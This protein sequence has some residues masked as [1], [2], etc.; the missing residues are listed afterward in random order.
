MWSSFQAARVRKG[1][2]SIGQ[3]WDPASGKVD[4][5][6]LSGVVERTWNVSAGL[7]YRPAAGLSFEGHV[8]Y[9]DISNAGHTQGADRQH[10]TSSINL[11]ARW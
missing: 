8:G 9:S 7:T 10:V 4:N 2:G 6:P 11:Q 3:P 1:E 5:V